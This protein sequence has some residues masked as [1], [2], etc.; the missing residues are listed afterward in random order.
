MKSAVKVGIVGYG[1]M[2]RMHADVWLHMPGTKIVA[3]AEPRK[4]QQDNIKQAYGCAV[5]DSC[6]EMLLH[7]PG[8]DVVVVAT[9]APLHASHVRL[10]FSHGCH[11]ICEKPMAITLLQCDA[12]IAEAKRRKLKLAI[13]HQSIFSR[14]VTVAEQKIKAGDIGELYAIKAYGKGRIAC[15]DLMEIAGTCCILCGILPEVK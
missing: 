1:M 12:M 7:R 14:A 6:E 13:N 15:S 10:A 4:D 11:V 2:G 3:I 5:Y 8:I 9:H